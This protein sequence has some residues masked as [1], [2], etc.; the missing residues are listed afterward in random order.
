MS[1]L[2]CVLKHTHPDAVTCR[3]YPAHPPEKWASLA[4]PVPIKQKR[5]PGYG[6]RGSRNRRSGLNVKGSLVVMCHGMP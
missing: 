1:W 5:R 3:D 6:Y 4:S 2:R